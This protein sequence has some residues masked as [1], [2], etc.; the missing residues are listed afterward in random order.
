MEHLPALLGIGTALAVGAASPGPSFVMVARTA[1]ASSRVDALCA[2]LGMAVGGLFFAVVSLLGLHGLLL[3]VPSLYWI[4]KILGG[5]YLVYLGVRIW[6]G[7]R[8][9]L[10][11][12]VTKAESGAKSAVRSFA[13]GLGTQVS[14]PKAAIVYSSV[15]AAFMP[16]APSIAFNLS[17]VAMVFSIEAGWYIFVAL[18]LSANG[19]RSVYL[20]YKSWIDRVA[21]GV[22][23]ALGLKLVSAAN[24]P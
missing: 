1:V 6:L 22:M 8:K 18:A 3:A 23:V 11:D 19:P 15:F 7:A 17:V 4:L 12:Q 16:A 20:R 14:N 5:S 2:A 21:G 13:L 9:P 10:F 24:R